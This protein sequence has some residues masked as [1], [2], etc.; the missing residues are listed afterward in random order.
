MKTSPATTSRACSPGRWVRWAS[1]WML[2]SR[3]CP[4]TGRSHAQVRAARRPRDRDAQ[5]LGGQTAADFGE[6]LVERR[7]E[8][9]AVGRASAVRAA[10]DKLGGE[11]VAEEQARNYCLACA[12]TPRR[13]F[14]PTRRCGGFPCPRPRPRSPFRAN[15]LS[16]GGALR[17]VATRAEARTVREAAR[18]AG[19]QAT[20]FRGG[21]EEQRRSAGVFHPLEP[22][23]AKLHREL[24]ASFDPDAYSPRPDVS[25]F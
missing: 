18:R 14:A 4:A 23:M 1:S 21:S 12:S 25:D 8:C 2:R 7:T 16:S 5:P 3:F 17:W 13:S 10:C 22:A 9:A 24:K 15:S 19:G 20:L 11:R 6:C